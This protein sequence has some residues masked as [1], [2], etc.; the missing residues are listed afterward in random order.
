MK[1]KR[2][3][4]FSLSFLDCICCGLGAV[5][6]LFVLV[7]ARSAIRQDAVASELKAEVDRLETAVMDGRQ[8]LVMARNA[9]ASI[10]ERIVTTQGLAARLIK[11][12]SERKTELADRDK[13]TVAAKAHANKLKSDLKAVEEELRRLKAGAKVRDDQG[14]RL[15]KFPG[16]GDR[17]YLTDLK[18]GGQRILILV[19]RSA[20][21]LDETVVGIVRRRNLADA[22]KTRAPKWQR[23]VATVDWLTTQLPVTAKFQVIGFSETAEP[24]I[25]GTR[26]AW[27]DAG[28]VDRLNQA[29]ERMRRAV[30]GDGTSL[31]NAVKAIGDLKPAPDNVFLLTDGLPTMGEGKPWRQRVSGEKR[32]QLFRD[33]AGRLPPGVPVNIILYPMEGDP[34]AA[35][36][37]W[38]LARTTGGAFIS[39]SADWP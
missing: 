6:L 19:D 17:Q 33:A 39:P 22:E 37:Y 34:M 5:I 9:L 32:L 31:L 30:P 12:M 38:H 15:R 13:E 28:S 1:R 2:L 29:V 16:H 36:A 10:D 4:V 3:N 23:V 14:D 21:M 18:M 7:N 8:N 25:P 26:G 11:E 20:S 24:L 35:D 27:L